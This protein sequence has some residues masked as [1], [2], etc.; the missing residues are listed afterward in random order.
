MQYFWHVGIPLL[1]CVE[2]RLDLNY[3]SYFEQEVSFDR[4][5][6][7]VATNIYTRGMGLVSFQFLS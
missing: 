4:S 3:S 5:A 6:I 1:G 7:H 2:K